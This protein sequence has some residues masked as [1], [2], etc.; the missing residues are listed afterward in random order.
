MF[1][2]CGLLDLWTLDLWTFSLGPLDLCALC[3][4][5][6]VRVVSWLCAVRA[7]CLVFINKIKTP[8]I[9]QHSAINLFSLLCFAAAHLTNNSS[10]LDQDFFVFL[11]FFVAS[12]IIFWKMVSPILSAQVLPLAGCDRMTFRCVLPKGRGLGTC[13]SFFFCFGMSTPPRKEPGGCGA[14]NL[15][16]PVCCCAGNRARGRGR[17]ARRCAYK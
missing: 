13:A 9:H 14:G 11:Y 16:V 12:S 15:P 5:S 4:C 3:G 6:L 1:F 2:V 17:A 7:P 10:I 8:F